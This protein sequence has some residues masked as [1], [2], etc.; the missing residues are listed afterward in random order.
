MLYDHA[1]FSGEEGCNLIVAGTI[2]SYFSDTVRAGVNSNRNWNCI[3]IE[4][5]WVELELELK[6]FKTPELELEL[7]FR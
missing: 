2:L 5:K 4:S 7:T 6:I 1:D 3:G